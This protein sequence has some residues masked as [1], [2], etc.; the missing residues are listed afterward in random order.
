VDQNLRVRRAGGALDMDPLDPLDAQQ[1]VV[2][3]ARV[4]ERDLS[5]Q[6]H[7]SRVDSLPYA[8]PVIKSAIQTSVASVMQSGQMTDDL[9]DFLCTAYV[10]LADYIESELVE[11]MT[12]FRDSAAELAATAPSPREK[13][14]TAAWQTVASS[15]ALAGEVARTIAAEAEHLRQEFDTLIAS[16]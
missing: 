8:K 16:S 12:Q 5:E 15:G 11:L 4:L 1:V 7:P 14:A 9:R 13:T 10:S 6:R 2:E 3:Y